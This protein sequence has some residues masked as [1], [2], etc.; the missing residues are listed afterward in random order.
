MAILFKAS[1]NQS[2]I[3]DPWREALISTLFKGGKK[4]C[5]KAEN[6]RPVSLTPISCKV[7]E[8]ILHSNIMKHLGNNNILTDYNMALENID[9]ARHNQNQNCKWPCKINKS[10]RADSQY[11]ARF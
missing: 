2:D 10:R 5:N 8:H 3:A 1:L 4:D 9:P 11:T 7:L 6:C